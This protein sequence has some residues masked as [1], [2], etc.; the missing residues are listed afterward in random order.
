MSGITH[1]LSGSYTYH[2]MDQALSATVKLL[3]CL[4]A[5]GARLVEMSVDESSGFLRKEGDFKFKVGGSADEISS[6]RTAFE[7]T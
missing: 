1:T 2:G 7:K 3:G 4:T 6:F 5:S